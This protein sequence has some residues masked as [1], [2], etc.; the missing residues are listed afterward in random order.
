MTRAL[1]GDSPRLTYAGRCDFPVVPPK[2]QRKG[3]HDEGLSTITAPT[4][5]M[6][7]SHRLY[8]EVSQEGVVYG[9]AER[10]GASVSGTSAT[11]GMSGGGGTFTVGSCP[12]VGEYSA[13]VC[14]GG[15]CGLPEGEEGDSYCPDV[16]GQG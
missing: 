1:P 16:S 2:A 15:D 7:I 3:S 9:A 10:P 8:S 11:E 6:Q 13:Q 4:V 12:Y 5:G 14:G